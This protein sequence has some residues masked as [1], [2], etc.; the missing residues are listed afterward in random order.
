MLHKGGVSGGGVELV[1][2]GDLRADVFDLVRCTS[3]SFIPLI[4]PSTTPKRTQ[5]LAKLADSFI[6]VVSKMGVTGVSD[7]VNQS[8]PEMLNRIRSV[9]NAYLAVGFGVAT[10]EH[11]VEVGEHSDGVVIGSKLVAVLR[12]AQGSTAER[13]KA[14]EDY[15][16]EITGKKTGGIQRKQPLRIKDAIDIPDSIP[17]P[18]LDGVVNGDRPPVPGLDAVPDSKGILRPPRFGKFGGQYVPEA[19]YD[20]H[21]ELEKAY[22]DALNDPAFWKEFESHYEYI[23]RPSELYFAERLTEYAGGAN[24]WLKRED[25]NH[26]GSHK[27]NNAIGQALLA[28]RLG[29]PRI[30]AETGAGQHGVAT[31]TAC[32]KFGLECVVYMGAED[33][34]RQALNVFR[35]KMLGAKV[36]AV[37]S[38][39]K[40]LKDAINEANR[41]WV[42]NL[43]NTHYI[44]G[45][46]IGPHPFPSI[47]RE[48]QQVIGAETKKQMQEKRG[49]L[50]EAVVACVGGG[51]NAIGEWAARQRQEHR[52][53]Q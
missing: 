20:C 45:S 53:R 51:S 7:K 31:A 30:I 33:V 23:G 12:D 26:T 19:L 16:A 27:I 44:V 10:R 39:S 5:H 6:Y 3:M 18:K 25:L 21:A 43:S 40:T 4:A 2:I 46:A 37:E 48:F 42:T 17:T 1:A 49:K 52:R 9:S 22:L 8:L 15:C 24:I 11:F 41:D 50:P 13:A 32:A 28:K 34:R 35:M 38:G 29:K 36:V 14:G 47:V